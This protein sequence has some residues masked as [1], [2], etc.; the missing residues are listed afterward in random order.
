MKKDNKKILEQLRKI[1]LAKE[2]FGPI[3]DLKIMEKSFP[4]A[5]HH[6][7]MRSPIDGRLFEW[8]DMTKPVKFKQRW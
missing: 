6:T 3:S 4:E 1:E 2:V 8:F 7:F 5:Q